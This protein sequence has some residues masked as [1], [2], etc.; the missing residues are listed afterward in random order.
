MH[1]N[2]HVYLNIVIKKNMEV[3]RLSRFYRRPADTGV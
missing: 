3:W 2:V 1:I